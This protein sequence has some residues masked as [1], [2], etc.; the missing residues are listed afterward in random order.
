[1]IQKKTLSEIST[2]LDR[3]INAIEKMSQP[4]IAPVVAKAPVAK[5]AET[6]VKAVTK[7]AV[8][9]PVKKEVKAP[10]KKVATKKVVAKKKK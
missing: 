3:L 2:K 1:M 6:K 9:T 5:V 7:V 8:K 10:A 4:K